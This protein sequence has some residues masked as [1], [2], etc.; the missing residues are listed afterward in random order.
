MSW[1]LESVHLFEPSGRLKERIGIDSSETI[2][3]YYIINID[4]MISKSSIFASNS[5]NLFIFLS[6]NITTTKCSNRHWS[7]SSFIVCFI[8]SYMYNMENIFWVSH[9][10]GFISRLFRPIK[11]HN[12]RNQINFCHISRGCHAITSLSLVQK[13][14]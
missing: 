1:S 6:K 13:W 5:I 4:Q 10:L 7:N 12:I 2:Q 11:W 14:I 3:M 8:I 9:I